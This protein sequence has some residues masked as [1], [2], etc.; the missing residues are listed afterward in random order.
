LLK[1]VFANPVCQ[2]LFERLHPNFGIWLANYSSK[3][4]RAATGSTDEK[5][6]GE[7]NE[8]L[9]IYS[10]EQYQIQPANYF[11]FGHRHLPLEIPIAPDS[12]YINLGDWIQYFT[13]GVFDGEKMELKKWEL[14]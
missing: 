9:V 2:W 8:W 3:S 11:V 6:L 7:E 5:F 10:K 1:K 12:T 13:Y 14:R 4:S